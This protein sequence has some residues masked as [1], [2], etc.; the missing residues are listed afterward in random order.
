MHIGDAVAFVLFVPF[1][2]RTH[3]VY[4]NILKLVCGVYVCVC[5]WVFTDVYQSDMIIYV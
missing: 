4:S 1:R 5:N 2:V 3:V